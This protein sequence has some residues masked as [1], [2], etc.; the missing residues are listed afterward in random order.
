M[1]E[2]KKTAETNLAQAVAAT[3][4]A[5]AYDTNVKFLLADRQIL[6]RILKYAVQEFAQMP[7]EEIMES[8]GNDIE[9]A[10]RPVDPG[11]SNLGRIRGTSTE[12]A[13][14]GEGVIMYDVRF[15]AYH[16]DAEMKF[17][18]NIEAQKSSDPKK[19]G[20]HLENRISYY[21]ARM[22]SA[23]KHTEFFKSDYDN[24]KKVRSIWICMGNKD[25][26]GDSIV[27]LGLE[28]T[29]VFGK[30]PGWQHTDLMRAVIISLREG[31]D[32][33][34]SKNTLIAMLETL[35]SQEDAKKK[36]R[37]LEETYGMVMTVELEGRIQE[38]CNLSE[39]IEA[40]GIEKGM[41]KERI[42][43]IIRMIRARA[44][45]EQILSYGYTEE[46]FAAAEE[47]L[48]VNV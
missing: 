31:V 33:K 5:G 35:L 44:A 16:K 8:I 13:V 43:A 34:T 3:D 47:S 4:A 12:D 28:Y 26:D 32:L 25:E 21:L 48:Y 30:Q 39:N 20:Y 17:L 18:L 29:P 37:V 2:T 22:I 27:A 11:L 19:L 45:K 23:Q 41:Q 38:M 14:P 1:E 40:R 6:A 10:A 46:E 36:T 24:L 15:S 9:V 42:D 7:V